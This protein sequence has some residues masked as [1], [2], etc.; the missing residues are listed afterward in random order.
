MSSSSPTVDMKASWLTLGP[1]ISLRPT[2]SRRV[3]VVGEIAQGL[4][5]YCPEGILK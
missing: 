1:S 2:L 5:S 4:L 3:A